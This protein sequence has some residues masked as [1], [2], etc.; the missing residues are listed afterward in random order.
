MVIGYRKPLG[1]QPHILFITSLIQLFIHT[2][3]FLLWLM[4]DAEPLYFIQ[5]HT[6][7]LLHLRDILKSQYTYWYASRWRRSDFKV[8]QVFYGFSILLLSC[9]ADVGFYWRLDRLRCLFPHDSCISIYSTYRVHNCLYSCCSVAVHLEFP[10]GWQL[11]RRSASQFL[12]RWSGLDSNCLYNTA[13]SIYLPPSRFP[14]PSVR[15]ASGYVRFGDPVN[16][17]IIRCTYRIEC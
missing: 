7:A 2:A 4:V 12:S 3:H 8:C 17:P 10:V 16:Q 13:A 11:N 14:R 5:K 9:L 15:S 6:D 1:S